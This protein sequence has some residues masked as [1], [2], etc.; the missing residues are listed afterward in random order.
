MGCTARERQMAR[1]VHQI[2][3][4][5]GQNCHSMALPKAKPP[6]TPGGAAGGID[7]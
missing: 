2:M 3:P 5:L 7:V 1:A 6:A 4:W